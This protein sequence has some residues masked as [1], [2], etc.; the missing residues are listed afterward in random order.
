M[1]APNVSLDK[2]AIRYGLIISVILI[3]FFLIMKATGLAYIYELRTLNFFILAIGVYKAMKHM[4]SNNAS[5]SYFTGL[6]TGF[7]TSAF[8]LLIFAVFLFIYTNIL[9]PDFMTHLQNNAPFG[10]YLNPYIAS[11]IIFFEGSIS[12]L[13]L[14]F[15][16]MQYMKESHM[17]GDSEVI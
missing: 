16:L 7:L 4:K 1:E 15:G 17:T 11:F 8:S 2:V 13:I 9:D 5:F 6:G 14:S 3:A 12:G 10:E